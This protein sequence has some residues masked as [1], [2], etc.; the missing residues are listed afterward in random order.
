[1][2]HTEAHVRGYRKN[3][4]YNDTNQQANVQRA[5]LWNN[6]CFFLALDAPPYGYIHT[7][8]FAHA[9]IHSFIPFDS[10]QK[11]IAGSITAVQ[12]HNV[13][14]FRNNVCFPDA[15]WSV[16]VAWQTIHATMPVFFVA[17][18][19]AFGG[20][21]HQRVN[22]CR[23]KLRYVCNVWKNGRHETMSASPKIMR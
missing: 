9:K 6:G 12:P 18:C 3:R 5:L 19:L 8:R 11:H 4:P 1:M 20:C 13:G 14:F 23:T 2:S 17:K 21:K 15:G 16:S 7:I 10:T 22:V